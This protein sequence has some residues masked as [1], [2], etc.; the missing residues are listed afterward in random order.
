MKIS[1]T[2][3][4]IKRL[5]SDQ[6][7]VEKIRAD[8]VEGVR[9]IAKP[10]EN[11]NWIYRI[12]V[13]SLGLVVVATVGGQIYLKANGNGAAG[14]EEGIV[15]LASAAVGALAGLLAPVPRN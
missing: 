8:P 14:L 15:A 4:L 2:N 3:E 9:E 5:E 12:V 7:L 6:A 11:D 13:S 10:L 1:T